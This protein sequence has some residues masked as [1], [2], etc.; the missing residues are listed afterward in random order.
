MGG[1]T[2]PINP[3]NPFFYLFET[4]ARYPCTRHNLLGSVAIQRSKECLPTGK[5]QRPSTEMGRGEN[6]A[7]TTLM[8]SGKTLNPKDTQSSANPSTRPKGFH[9]VSNCPQLQIHLGSDR[10]TVTRRTPPP[11]YTL[12]TNTL[13]SHHPTPQ[14]AQ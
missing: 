7:F 6:H 9:D 5:K 13:R 2:D 12:Q 8:V 1:A 4:S 10:R 3:A 11:K 14:S